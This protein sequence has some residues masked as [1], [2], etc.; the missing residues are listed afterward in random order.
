MAYTAPTPD[1]LKARY[2]AFVEIDEAAIDRWL[3]EAAAECFGWAEGTRAR[4]EM[5]YAAHK[6]V[7]TGVLASAV[8]AGLTSFRSGD[9]V[10]S[11]DSRAAS[12]TGFDSTV[13]GREFLDLRRRNFAGPRLAWTPPG[14][15]AS[16]GSGSGEG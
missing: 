7:E 14:I 12:R 15:V 5:A 6:L 4:A 1:E 9:F 16:P 2:P 13:Y 10:A 11:V 3:D 8:P